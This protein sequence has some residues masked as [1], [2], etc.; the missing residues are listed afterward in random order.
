MPLESV[1]LDDLVIDDDRSLRHIAVYHKL[2][3]MLVASGYRFYK[4]VAGTSISWDRAL[5][6]NLTFWDGSDGADV[7]CDEH[8][9]ADVVAHV[10]WHH[11]VDRQLAGAGSTAEQRRSPAAL[12]LAE[13]IA[14]AFDLYLV[15][16]MLVNTPDSDF[17]TSQVPLM[18]EAA[19]EAGLPQEGFKTLLEQVSR[20][21]ER[22]FEDLRVLL[23]DIC[24]ELLSC[25]DA[26]H[27][28][29]VLANHSAHRFAPLLHHFQLSNWVLYARAYG[30]PGS[31]EWVDR[32]DAELRRSSDSLTWLS[33]HWLVPE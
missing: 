18:G 32:T 24:T 3:A 28:E 22:A 11:V 10:A 21:P 4:P 20:E 1:L 2:K 17:I 15:G 23:F 26:Q 13:A 30:T 14:S 33:E 31:N 25:R 8:I 6:L 29:E 5:F 9:A 27:A 19:E 7:L 16:R 12:F